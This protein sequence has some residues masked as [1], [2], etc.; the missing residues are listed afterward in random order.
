MRV[1]VFGAGGKTGRLVVP[2]L[3]AAGIETTGVVHRDAS[4]EVVRAAGGVPI[5]VDLEG[6]VTPVRGVLVGADAVV[7]AAGADFMT[8]PEHSERLD[9]H[10]NIRA[11]E[12]AREAGVDRWIQISSL[13]ADRID[14]APPPLQA[15]LHNKAAADDAVRTS[16]MDWTVLRP[17]GLLDD[18]ATGLLDTA[19][20]AGAG[21]IRYTRADLAQVIAT[22]LTDDLLRNKEF[23]LGMGTQSIGEALRAL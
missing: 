13:Y 14:Q 12:A 11:V 20:A 18:D 8:G 17:G 23:D 3:T 9:R 19:P 7:W 21:F 6:E 5:I 16:G 15:F 10:G 2:L 4:V 22:A 1:V